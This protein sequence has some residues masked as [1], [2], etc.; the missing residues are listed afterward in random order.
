MTTYTTT[1]FSR[2][3]DWD[4][5]TY[6]DYQASELQT[7][8]QDGQGNMVYSYQWID[9]TGNAPEFVEMFDPWSHS[10]II[11][12]A[13]DLAGLDLV[14]GAAFAERIIF[15]VDWGAGKT[16]YMLK[17]FQPDTG[18]E[19]Y[20]VIGGDAV[21][22][23]N[24]ATLNT[25][26]ANPHR[27]VLEGAFEGGQQISLAGFLDTTFTQNDNVTAMDGVAL[28]WDGGVGNDTLTGGTNNDTLMGGDG[29]DLMATGGGMDTM[30]GG[31]GNDTMT[32]S[33]DHTNMLGGAG[34]DSLI[35]GSAYGDQIDGGSGNDVVNLSDGQLMGGVWISHSHTNGGSGQDSIFGGLAGDVAHGGNGGD[36]LFGE[37]GDDWLQ[38]GNG[39]DEIYGGGWNDSLAGGANDDSVMGGTGNDIID[40]GTGTDSLY[41]E[42]GLDSM[43]GGAGNDDLL[44]GKGN[45]S[46]LGGDGDDRLYGDD[47]N[48]KL[49]G[50][51]GNDQL[52]GGNHNDRLE[53]GDG[54]DSLRGDAGADTLIG[55]AGNDT[56]IGN[57]GVDNLYGMAGADVFKF[58][59][60]TDSPTATMD[61]IL[62]GFAHNS[63][64]ID[65]SAIDANSTLAG[66][67]AFT[68]VGPALPFSA[69]GQ[70]RIST[71]GGD[72]MIEVNT[73]GTGGAEMA[74]I[75]IGS[76]ALT[77][78]D[79]IL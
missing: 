78:T 37:A 29:N 44:G 34:D 69:P 55:G 40:G 60:V 43:T 23:T 67:Q 45:D 14:N 16:T 26:L 75:V 33:G 27:Y 62:G 4:S 28:A 63:D 49:Y 54:N 35:G 57:A 51:L 5:Q 76:V 12:R 56:L 3:Y 72:T 1:G 8:R 25:F 42:D 30:F 77:G 22:I 64:K 46:V 21:N 11:T 59:A 31:I 38:G 65:L 15:A 39:N 52:S 79:F 19:N 48:D 71:L 66:N 50:D 68:V 58:L 6:G 13:S 9:E 10:M 47:N 17:T 61:Q 70:V 24:L 20:F 18:V 32:G 74:I 41:G 2:V 73:T 53:G 7:I 36:Q